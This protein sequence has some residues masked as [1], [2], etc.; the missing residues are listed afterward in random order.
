MRDAALRRHGGMGYGRGASAARAEA[1][2]RARDGHGC[3]RVPQALR[4]VV[5]GAPPR[6][7]RNLHDLR[8]EINNA[9]SLLRSKLAVPF[10]LARRRSIVKI[11]LRL[12]RASTSAIFF[13]TKKG[14][15]SFRAPKTPD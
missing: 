1:R 8:G 10:Q 3:E 15:G 2:R 7:T 6:R 12:V 13:V 5:E 4:E 11:V 9:S 14:I